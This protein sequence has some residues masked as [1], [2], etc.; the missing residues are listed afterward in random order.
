M[1]ELFLCDRPAGRTRILLW[2]SI[3]VGLVLVYG[4]WTLLTIESRPEERDMARWP[5]YLLLALG[6]GSPLG[7]LLHADRFIARIARDGDEVELDV[8]T[9]GGVRRRRLPVEAFL[10]SRYRPGRRL[11][12]GQ[13]DHAPFAIL[14]IAGFRLPFLADLNAETLDEAGLAPIMGEALDHWRRTAPGV[15]QPG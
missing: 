6:I 3:V 4:A 7:M 15:R 5:A 9:P 12:R 14:K 2:T 13:L 8:V 11:V 1:N 10:G